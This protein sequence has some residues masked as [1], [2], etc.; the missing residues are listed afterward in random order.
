MLKSAEISSPEE[1]SPSKGSTAIAVILGVVLAVGLFIAV[2]W[3]IGWSIKRWTTFDNVGVIS[4]IEGCSRLLI[5][6]IY[7][8]LV[9][10]LSDIKRTFMYHGAEHR[11]INC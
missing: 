1:E 5:F 3:F 7:I 11:T 4:V 9:R 6:I 8:A 10:L 2:P